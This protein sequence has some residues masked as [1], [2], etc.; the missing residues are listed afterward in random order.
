MELAEALGGAG[1]VAAMMEAMLFF[2]D[3]EER[4][5]L[6]S[7]GGSGGLTGAAAFGSGAAGCAGCGFLLGEAL[8]S[9]GQMNL[10]VE[11]TVQSLNSIVV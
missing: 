2:G 6:G 4:D 5:D 8:A 1:R 10:G 7:P 9:P 11:F 3:G